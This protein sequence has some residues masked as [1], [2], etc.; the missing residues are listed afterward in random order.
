MGPGELIAILLGV[1]AGTTVL[2]SPVLITRMILKHREKVL[3]V[4]QRPDAAPRLAEEVAALRREVA[5]LRE[6]TGKFDMSFDA[7][8]DRLEERVG[9][10]ENDRRGVTAAPNP[11]SA[12]NVLRR[13]SQS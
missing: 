7:A 5:E 11:E 1:G 8:L 6:T 9:R 13:S 10:V 4:N 3:G 12:D 2:L